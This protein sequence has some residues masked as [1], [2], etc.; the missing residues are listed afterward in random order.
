MEV[1][2]LNSAM[3]NF[4]IYVLLKELQMQCKDTQPHISHR[5]FTC[6][7]L[8]ST[9]PTLNS[10]LSGVYKKERKLALQ[11][12]KDSPLYIIFLCIAMQAHS[13]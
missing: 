2:T 5:Y 12:Q 10:F 4:F 13:F 9:P 11:E 1:M 8:L 6:V 3:N 7:L